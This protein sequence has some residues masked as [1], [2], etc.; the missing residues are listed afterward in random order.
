[1]EADRLVGLRAPGIVLKYILT[2]LVRCAHCGR[3]MTPTSS[4]EYQTKDGTAKR[5]VAYACPGRPDGTCNNRRRI[6][7][8]WLRGIVI[9]LM[10]VQL[11]FGE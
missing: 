11:S 4:A 9:E 5:Y 2:G 3:A 6:P 1:M 7:E 8:P 10:R